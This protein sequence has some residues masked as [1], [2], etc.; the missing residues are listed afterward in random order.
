M[1]S[2]DA[3]MQNLEA[4]FAELPSYFSG[5]LLLSVSAL[6]LGLLLSF[7]LA[8]LA[9]RQPAIKGPILTVTSLVQT[10]PSMALLA[11]MVP[12]LGG[13]IGFVPAFMALTLYSMLP[14]LRN[15]VTGI[16]EIDPALQEA[17]LGVGMTDW[18]SLMKVELPLAMPVIV[19]GI[20]TATVWV[21]GTA[22][23]STPVGAESLGNYIFAGLQTRN[24]ISVLFGCFCSAALAIV[25]DQLIRLIEL[26]YTT[27]KP[28]LRQ[29]G[30]LGL[31]LVLGFGL[32][33]SM[34][35]NIMRQIPA[36]PQTEAGSQPQRSNGASRGT[37]ESLQS[38][39][40]IIGAKT[41]TEQY[42]LTDLLRRQLENA[43]ADVETRTNLGST[44]LFD[45]L[46]NNTVDVYIDYTG[47][48]WAT[49]MGRQDV[50]DRT[51]MF[52]EM[53]QYLADNHGIVTLGRLGFE[54]AYGFAMRRDRASQ[55]NIASLADI[56]AQRQDLVV[57]GDP[58]F[59]GRKEWQDVVQLYQLENIK[60]RSMDSTFMYGAVRDGHV[61]LIGAY[62]TD[63]RIAAYDLVLL[64]DPKRSLPPYDAVIL[65]S[66][67]ASSNTAL[68]ETLK[69]LIN[70]IPD[71]LMR[72]ANK[73]VEL[74]KQLPKNAGAFLYENIQHQERIKNQTE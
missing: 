14:V 56:T 18:Q 10:I 71:Q 69:V 38:T 60:T 70:T 24:W 4:R 54:N 27:R 28:Q 25:L 65:L 17:A 22:T 12:L 9:T 64:K 7:P 42:I 44:I 72:R 66:P 61:D 6:S 33:L 2:T 63:G 31:V 62:T 21:V 53:A 49:I 20:R 74:E 29:L 30:G 26:S 16:T 59:F 48:I 40:I 23:L 11:L 15:T 68:T 1:Q 50:V 41:F 3:L 8:I 58:E 5:H 39:P 32:S 55:L 51:V 73:M 37:V 13:M 36:V 43:G 46:A 19:A 52:I 35:G 57:G 67:E 34:W 47:T 45:A